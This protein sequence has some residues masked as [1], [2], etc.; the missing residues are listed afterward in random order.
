MDSQKSRAS[1][2]AAPFSRSDLE[3]GAF[4]LTAAERYTLSY[5]RKTVRHW[6]LGEIPCERMGAPGRSAARGQSSHVATRIDSAR[7]I[8]SA[9]IDV[10]DFI[11]V[12]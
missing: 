8:A 10:E 2:P 4:T 5:D 1:A 12:C 11:R 7:A 9:E 3:G 6:P